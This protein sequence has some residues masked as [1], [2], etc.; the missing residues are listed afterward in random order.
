MAAL[1]RRQPGP[2]PRST[3]S[4]A[5]H[6]PHARIPGGGA[7]AGEGTEGGIDPVDVGE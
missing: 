4:P 6:A 5:R 2:V 7:V 1:S 3:P